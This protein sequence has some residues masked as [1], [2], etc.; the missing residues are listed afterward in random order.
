MIK[1][2]R[3]FLFLSHVFK[4]IKHFID[5]LS[6]VLN[7]YIEYFSLV[8]RFARDSETKG[9]RF[10]MFDCVDEPEKESVPF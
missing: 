4:V 2:Y 9:N 5:G 10:C 1:N 8:I 6:G 3:F 7:K